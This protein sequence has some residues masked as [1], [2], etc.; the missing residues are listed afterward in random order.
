[1][2]EVAPPSEVET[3]EDADA[4]EDVDVGPSS[5]VVGEKKEKVCSAPYPAG[6]MGLTD[7]PENRRPKRHQGKTPQRS[8]SRQVSPLPTT[9][10]LRA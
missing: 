3:R 4:D 8:K 5:R 1:V 2:M 9:L 7:F 6:E 10:P